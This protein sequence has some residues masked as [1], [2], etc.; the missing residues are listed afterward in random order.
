MMLQ[1]V[2]NQERPKL[3]RDLRLHLPLKSYSSTSVTLAQKMEIP[4]S[5]GS[6]SQQKVLKRIEKVCEELLTLSNSIPS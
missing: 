2:I 1:R 6:I 3:S 4:E 5:S